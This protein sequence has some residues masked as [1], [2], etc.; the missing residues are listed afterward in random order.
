MLEG[1]VRYDVVLTCEA[2]RGDE[3]ELFGEDRRE[4]DERGVLLQERTVIRERDVEPLIDEGAHQHFGY[5]ELDAER[6][7]TMGRE[8]LQRGND[9][10][11][12]ELG[13]RPDADEPMRLVLARSRMG[14]RIGELG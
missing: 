14:D 4:R 13:S 12:A 3:D 1:A 2:L 9:D 6:Q 10:P 8:A 7:A 5:A 11:R